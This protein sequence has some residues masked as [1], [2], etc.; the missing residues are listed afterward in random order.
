MYL[1]GRTSLPPPKDSRKGAGFC[2]LF[3]SGGGW[4][5]ESST[6]NN[7]PVTERWSLQQEWR[8]GELVGCRAS[9]KWGTSGAP[10]PGPRLE[11]E[12]HPT[13]LQICNS[14]GDGLQNR[15]C[16]GPQEF[17]FWP[18]WCELLLHAQVV[19]LL[20][21]P[22][23]LLFPLLLLVPC[24][25]IPCGSQYGGLNMGYDYKKECSPA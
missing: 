6:L 9:D 4:G 24:L 10:I 1:Q 13:S 12:P 7:Q 22:L 15:Q 17:R 18:W 3:V 25:T 19:F 2:C 23:S 11:K 20:L 8:S 14:W 16:I 21:K 5:G